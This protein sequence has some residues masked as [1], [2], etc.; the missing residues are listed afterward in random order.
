MLERGRGAESRT[1]T[2]SPEVFLS[3]VWAGERASKMGPRN[4]LATGVKHP[5]QPLP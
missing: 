4:Y 3:S 1:R 5:H 2:E